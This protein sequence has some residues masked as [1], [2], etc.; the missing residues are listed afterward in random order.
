M[1]DKKAY[2]KLADIVGKEFITDDPAICHAYSKDASLTS[3]WRKHHRDS[4]TVPGAVVLPRDTED[5][6]SVLRICDRE[7][8]PVVTINTGVNMCGVCIPKAADSLVLDLKR[9]DRILNIDEENMTAVIQ[10]HVNFARLQ[11][12]TM[13]R[14]LWNG[15]T[16]LAPGIVGVLSNMMF[17]EIWQSALAYGP[18]IKSLINMK[19][20]LPNGGHHR[21]RFTVA[22]ESRR[23]LVGRPRTVPQGYFRIYPLWRAW[24]RHRSHDK[25]PPL[26][27]RRMASGKK[28]RPAAVAGKP[29]HLLY[30]VS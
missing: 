3:V 10:P 20:V 30:R 6:R 7:R 25:T 8:V 14:G 4:I 1:I 22:S 2:Q 12:E 27:R 29:S 28:L 16:P 11:S 13:K 17:N 26:G 19:V 9:L 23:F 5:V 24:R 18:G 15:G 21:N